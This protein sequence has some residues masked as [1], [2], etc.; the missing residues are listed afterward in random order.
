MDISTY[1]TGWRARAAD[2]E[3]ANARR[4]ESLG[5][6]AKKALPVLKQ[7]GARKVIL[8]GSVALKRTHRHSDIDLA[9]EGIPPELFLRAFGLV[10]EAL[11]NDV[12]FDLVPLEEATPALRWAMDQGEV[13]FDC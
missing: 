6:Y 5:A 4:V 1:V 8:F 12:R 7:C 3:E 2:E 9:V 10:E 13:L 11:G